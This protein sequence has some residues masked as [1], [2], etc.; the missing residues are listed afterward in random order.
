MK[1]T[2]EQLKNRE[3]NLD[4]IIPQYNETEEV[5]KPLLSSIEN[6][7]GIDLSKINV[8]IVND[9]SDTKLSQSFLD[10]FTKIKIQYLETPEN[11]GPGQARQFGIDASDADYI[12]FADADDLFYTC[13][14]FSDILNVLI[15][16]SD[17][18]FDIIYTK[19]LEEII[20]NNN[21]ISVTHNPDITWLHGKCFRRQYLL[22]RNIRFNENIKV[23]EDSYFNVVAQMNA[24]ETATLD[25]LSYY[26]RF[27]P[28]SIT[29][30]AKYKYNYLVESAQDL[31]R[32]INDAADELIKRKTKGRE[33]YIAK[34]ILFMYYLLQSSFWNDNLEND[35]D[36]QLRRRRFEISIKKTIIKYQD[37]LNEIPRA[38]F[39]RCKNGERAQCAANVGFESEYETWE[40]FINRLNSIQPLYT[41]T[42]A[43]CKHFKGNNEPCGKENCIISL[44]N[45]LEIYSIPTEYEEKEETIKETE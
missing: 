8:I 22:D 45:D 34:G 39:I 40:Q 27:N 16:Y 41:K 1:F 9:H 29:R 28:N 12:I 19:W 35:P 33:E 38:D 37:I 21:V 31:V 24:G 2:K 20:S 10:Q 25:A 13:T 26:W 44:D 4:V 42:C 5:I 7:V 14:I 3:F 15:N 30:N 43:T 36:L 18:E 32:S 17:K 6:Q 11:K 23:H